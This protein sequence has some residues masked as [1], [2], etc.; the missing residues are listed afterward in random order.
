MDADLLQHRKRHKSVL[1]FRE[2]T[3]YHE[4]HE[5]VTYACLPGRAAAVVRP[6]RSAEH[7]RSWVV[8]CILVFAVIFHFSLEKANTGRASL[9]ARCS[10]PSRSL[11]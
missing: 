5:T 1:T 9:T 8:N 10:G 4:L 2:R 11:V 3:D 6:A 7:A